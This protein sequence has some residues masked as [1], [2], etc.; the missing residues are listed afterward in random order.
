MSQLIS[1]IIPAYNR[2]NLIAETLKSVLEQTYTN[3]EC[4]IV[5][6][7]STDTTFEVLEKYALADKR[8]SCFRRPKN[9]AKGPSSS[10]NFGIE[11][12][13]GDF[14]IF[15]DSDDLLSSDCL[16]NRLAFAQNNLQYDFFIFKTEL[17]TKRI[18]DLN[19]IFNTELKSYSDEKYL[20]LFLRGLFPF[21]VSSVL[22][23]IEKIKF[24]EGFDEKMTILEDPE[25]HIKA[26]KNNLKSITFNNSKADNFYRKDF[27]KI[28][29]KENQQKLLQMT[30]YLFSKYLNHFPAQMRNYALN[31]YRSEVLLKKSIGFSRKFYTLFLFA[32]ILSFKQKLLIPI[33]LFYKFLKIENVKGLG[34]YTL[35]AK[36]IK[37]ETII[38]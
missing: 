12:A 1:I 9:K 31:F 25:L 15:L 29:N 4:I 26:F 13:K 30:Y 20:D 27:N 22:W 8:F 7:G 18:G 17:F 21:C 3:W 37:Q 35:A 16:S 23:K 36:Y 28:D 11:K 14:I 6:D 24:L 33:L 5:D 32:G 38:L 19:Q 10:R 34:F 2:E